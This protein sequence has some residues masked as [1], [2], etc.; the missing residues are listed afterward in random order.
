MS[1][2]LLRTGREMARVFQSE[3]MDRVVP[4]GDIDLYAGAFSTPEQK[5]LFYVSD[6]WLSEELYVVALTDRGIRGLRDLRG[7]SLV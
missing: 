1:D 7:K 3:S 6:L 4:S 2:A 5:K